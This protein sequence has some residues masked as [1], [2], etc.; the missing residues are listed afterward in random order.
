MKTQEGKEGK[1]TERAGKGRKKTKEGKEGKETE[2]GNGKARKRK[3]KRIGK[4]TKEGK[5]GNG[6]ERKRKGKDR[7]GKKTKEGEGEKGGNEDGDCEYG[8]GLYQL[9]V[10][11]GR[12]RHARSWAA[13][14]TRYR[15]DWQPSRRKTRHGAPATR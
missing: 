10:F 2:E 1:E 14:Q 7:K 13:K 9:M 12:H 5:E 8:I 3:G 11:V 4:K 15:T 6:Q